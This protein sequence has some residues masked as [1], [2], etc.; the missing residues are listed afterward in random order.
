MSETDDI[1]E[2]TGTD[3]IRELTD[4]IIDAL[5]DR[6]P[7]K[8]IDARV[9]EFVKG[10]AVSNSERISMSSLEQWGHVIQ[11]NISRN[12]MN[13]FKRSNMGD[14]LHGSARGPDG[15]RT[16]AGKITCD[17]DDPVSPNF[18]LTVRDAGNLPRM[19]VSVAFYPPPE[20]QADNVKVSDVSI[21]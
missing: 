14:F 11:H 10:L 7:D 4:I 3:S 2:L 12:L 16:M 21:M 20:L 13:M 1:R 6:L 17:L 15:V 9:D 18:T 19:S 5:M 8:D